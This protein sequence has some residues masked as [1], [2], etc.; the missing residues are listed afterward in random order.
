MQ[1]DWSLLTA[2]VDRGQALGKEWDFSATVPSVLELS[3]FFY[4]PLSL[5]LSCPDTCEPVL[6]GSPEVS[7]SI[8]FTVVKALPRVFSYS[9]PPPSVLDALVRAGANLQSVDA[10]QKTPLHYAAM[11]FSLS[12]SLVVVPVHVCASSWWCLFSVSSRLALS[13][14]LSPFLTLLLSCPAEDAWTE[15]CHPVTPLSPSGADQPLCQGR[16]RLLGASVFSFFLPFFSFP[17]FVPPE[18]S[19]PPLFLV[20]FDSPSAC[21]RNREIP[22][23]TSPTAVAS[24]W[25]SACVKRQVASLVLVQWRKN[26]EQP[27]QMTTCAPPPSLPPAAPASRVGG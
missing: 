14:F 8:L 2:F 11:V 10:S 27:R 5:R 23:L 19:P 1:S 22:A 12:L 4:C 25:C 16:G 3:L 24:T 18:S 7:G 9:L 17:I 26:N 15:R 6:S 20:S 13:F 21:S